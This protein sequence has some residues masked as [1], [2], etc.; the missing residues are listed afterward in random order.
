MS[1]RLSDDGGLELFNENPQENSSHT[2][3]SH[4]IQFF[5]KKKSLDGVKTRNVEMQ[6][7]FT[8][9]GTRFS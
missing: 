2:L 6:I 9:S 8:G 7:A 1:G 4:F 3:H 5:K